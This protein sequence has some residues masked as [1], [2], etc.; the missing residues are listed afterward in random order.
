MIRRTNSSSTKDSF[1][2]RR[3]STFRR[4]MCNIQ[5]SRRHMLIDNRRNFGSF[6]H[7]PIKEES[8]EQNEENKRQLMQ[9]EEILDTEISNGIQVCCDR[10]TNSTET[11]ILR[12]SS[13]KD[14]L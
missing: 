8:N 6:Q 1:I 11:K 13:Y 5:G 4:S 12:Q 7:G 2:F 14:M 3:Q 10:K 9:L